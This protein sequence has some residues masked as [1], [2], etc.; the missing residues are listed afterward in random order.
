[1]VV[2]GL[3]SGSLGVLLSDT[4]YT[5]LLRTLAALCRGSGG[6]CKQ[7]LQLEICAMLR[8][9]LVW[10]ATIV[11]TAGCLADGRVTALEGW[12]MVA[13][14]VLYVVTPVRRRCRPSSATSARRGSTEAKKQAQYESAHG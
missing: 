14:Y 11:I 13:F 7:L 2:G 5:M 9:V 12:L 8:D 10:G 1:M 4:T 3:A 6:L